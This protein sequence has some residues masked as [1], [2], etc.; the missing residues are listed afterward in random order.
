MDHLF[1]SKARALGVVNTFGV[2]RLQRNIMA[3]QQTLRV[4]PSLEEE[5]LFARSAEYWSLFELGPKV[6][7]VPLRV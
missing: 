5:S 6:R 7:A 3:L 2:K 1:I 4:M